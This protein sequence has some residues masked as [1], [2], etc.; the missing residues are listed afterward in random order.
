MDANHSMVRD[1]VIFL[2]SAV[3][4][5]PFF[6]KFG[7]GSV[8]GYLAAGSIIGPWGLRLINDA[9]SV[10]SLAEFGVVFLLFLIGLELRPARLWA[11]RKMVFGLGGAQMVACTVI[12]AA[13]FGVLFGLTST[14]SLLFAF[15]LSLSSTAFALQMLSERNE[16]KTEA[17]RASFAVLLFQDL[18]VIPVLALLPLLASNQQTH[19][20]GAVRSST[21]A[22][23]SILG[24]FAGGKYL[25]RPFFR[26][27]A[28][29]HT[30]EVFAAASL[31]V[32][33]GVSWLISSVGLSMALGAFL[34]GVVLSDSEYRH[35]LEANIDSFKGL[36]LGLFFISVG[37]TVDYGLIASEP[38]TVLSWVAVVLLV[39]FGVI[40]LL[41]KN[42]GF[43]RWTASRFATTL[44]QGG[45]F[46]F[47]LAT[48]GL[49]L[50]FFDE[51]LVHL[52]V[53]T[54]TITMGL[55]PF[56]MFVLDSFCSRASKKQTT[57]EPN[58]DIPSEENEIIIAGFGRVGQVVGRLLRMKNISFTA[59]EHDSEQVDVVRRFGSKVYFGDASRIDLLES[60]GAAKA[61][62]FFLCIDDVEASLRVADTVR[63]HFP[64]LKIFARAR[65][66][67]HAHQLMDLGIVTIVRETLASSIEMA[68]R[69]F[70]D[71]GFQR[72]T[73]STMIHN[74]REHDE[75]MLVEQ[76]KV[77]GDEQAMINVS[78]Q[79]AAQLAQVMQRDEAY[80]IEQQKEVGHK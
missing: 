19:F 7:L 71:M 1:S 40:W 75:K 11:L 12:L 18:A 48:I 26:W 51:H 57:V 64:N 43:N 41:G 36:L 28:A 14:V 73:I 53:V 52:L 77:Y 25:V 31:L 55:M 23:L 29:S 37:M 32:V 13:A 80:K 42:L 8:L 67:R 62:Y 79:A 17:G 46:A 74:F 35:E 39:K 21:L 72:D 38:G 44:I 78:K 69:A 20:D 50:Q 59:L 45:E 63:T 76:H 61:K 49:E 66:R 2:S 33:M 60:A 27:V 9:H 6:R 24:I 65:N 30:K 3:L 34:A 22:A 10:M 47:V 5:V 68:A 56:M 58:Y 4:C 70:I 54:V 15:A 16:L